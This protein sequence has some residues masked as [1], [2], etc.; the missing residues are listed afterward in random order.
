MR[1]DLRALPHVVCIDTEALAREHALPK[2]ANVILLGAAARFLS[3][4]SVTQLRESIARVFGSKGEAVVEMNRKAFDI[5]H[6]A[7]EVKA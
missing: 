4:L 6:A 2:C 5:G 3:I 7:A 1:A